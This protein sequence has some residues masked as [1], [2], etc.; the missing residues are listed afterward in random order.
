MKIICI[1]APK[2][3]NGLIKSLLND[4]IGTSLYGRYLKCLRIM[5]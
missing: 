1:T 4:I 5:A 3:L 2:F